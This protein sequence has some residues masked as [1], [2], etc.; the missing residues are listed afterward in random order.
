MTGSAASAAIWMSVCALLQVLKSFGPDS[1]L[2]LGDSRRNLAAAA[3][4]EC[5]LVEHVYSSPHTALGHLQ[6]A[7][8][9]LGMQTSVQGERSPPHVMSRVLY[10]V[11]LHVQ[12]LAESVYLSGESQLVLNCIVWDIMRRQE[13]Q[14]RKAVAARVLWQWPV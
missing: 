2:D 13:R 6:A 14:D 3:E 7:G 8:Q 4:L 11:T 9:A 5:A 10:D 1:T 12:R